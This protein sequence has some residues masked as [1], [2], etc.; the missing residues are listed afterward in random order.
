LSVAATIA[1]EKSLTAALAGETPV[2]KVAYDIS[3]EGRYIEGQVVVTPT[4]L[5]ITSDDCV[6]REITLAT[7]RDFKTTTMVGSGCLETMVDGVPTRLVR[8]N[9]RLLPY[10]SNLVKYLNKVAA[11]ETAPYF[12][13]IKEKTCPRCGLVYP[14]ESQICPKC[15]N[16]AQLVKR[17]LSLAKP[18]AWMI[19]GTMVLFWISTGARLISP[20]L[21]R[22]LIDE[23]IGNGNTDKVVFYVLLMS[24]VLLFNQGLAVARGLLTTVL[25]SRLGQDLRN[26]VYGKLQALSLNYISKHKTGDLMNRVTNDTSNI[27]SFVQNQAATFINDSLVFIGIVA[28][29]MANHWKLALL[30]LAPAPLVMFIMARMRATFRTMYHRQWHF[31]D[32]VNSLLQDILSGMRVV[33]TF[34]Q[35]KRE[36]ARFTAYSKDFADITARNETLFNT[37]F[38]FIGFLMGAGNFLVLYFGGRLVLGYE[39]SKGELIQFTQYAGMIWGPL[40]FFTFIPRW[41]TQTMTSAERVF[42]V[43]DEEPDVKDL[44]NARRHEIKGA[45]KFENVTFGY[46]SYEPVLHNINVDVQPGEMIGLVGHSGAGKSTFINLVCRFYDPD[47]GRVLVDGVDLRTV[48][49]SDIRSQIGVVLQE[50]F[51]FSGTIYENI[52][53]SKPDATPEEVIRA[54]KIA[55]AHDFIMKFRDGYDTKVGERG[56]RLSGGERQRISIARAILH[57]PRILILDEATASVDTDTEQQIQEALGRLVKNRTTF[58]IAHRLSTLRN[59]TRLLVLDKGCIAEEGTHEELYAKGG[60]YRRL[61]DAQMELFKMRETEI[62]GQRNGAHNGK[63]A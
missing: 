2:T 9:M 52:V 14:D 38:P 42:T 15:I 37:F 35:E 63:P 59:A 24:L 16:K 25:G 62:A 10:Y 41:F 58:A 40:Q 57:N 31:F 53:Y 7:C 44:P 36:V 48:L 19:L 33:K 6:I 8:F 60:I 23:G 27:Q 18:H 1:S 34:G 54:A 50:P 45:V 43:I 28:I 11:G 26:M 20:Q 12:E 47:E 39:M 55:N 32:R 46:R 13:E 4:R 21:T 5:L 3:P 17:L 30:V 51:L 61:V 22:L 29:L 56:Q 49:Q